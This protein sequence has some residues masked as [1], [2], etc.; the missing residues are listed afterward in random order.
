[1]DMSSRVHW[2]A[3][4]YEA[5]RLAARL[6]PSGLPNLVKEA[7]EVA[8]KV[9]GTRSPSQY[10][11][12]VDRILDVLTSL[13]DI[14]IS[15]NQ[16]QVAELVQFSEL[17][18]ESGLLLAYAPEI[19]EPKPDIFLLRRKVKEVVNSVR[20][21]EKATAGADNAEK[22]KAAEPSP[23]VRSSDASTNTD[24]E[25]REENIEDEDKNTANTD[26]EQPEV[27]CDCSDGGRSS[28]TPTQSKGQG[29][30]PKDT[31]PGSQALSP[32]PPPV[33]TS[34][35]LKS[36]PKLNVMSGSDTLAALIESVG[37]NPN[38]AYS[39][40]R[41][42]HGSAADP[43]LLSLIYRLLKTFPADTHP[44]PGTKIELQY[45]SECG[46]IE[47]SWGGVDWESSLATVRC[48]DVYKACGEPEE[49]LLFYEWEIVRSMEPALEEAP[50]TGGSSGRNAIRSPLLPR[51]N[52]VLQK[53]INRVSAEEASHSACIAERNT[54]PTVNDLPAVPDQSMAPPPPLVMTT[55]SKRTAVNT[56]NANS[57]EEPASGTAKKKRKSAPPR[58]QGGLHALLIPKEHKVVNPSA[59]LTHKGAARKAAPLPRRGPPTEMRGFQ[60]PA[61]APV[62][63]PLFKWQ[64]PSGAPPQ[65]VTP[66][67]LSAQLLRTTPHFPNVES[68]LGNFELPSDTSLMGLFE[69]TNPFALP[70]NTTEGPSATAKRAGEALFRQHLEAPN[71][72]ATND[73]WELAA[74]GFPGVSNGAI[75]QG[76]VSS[77]GP[78][79]FAALFSESK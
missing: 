36:M 49:F 79:M 60:L 75:S 38:R 4:E 42:A 27:A 43:T 67:P 14:L 70:R 68:L 23:R 57:L 18:S 35:R 13:K 37:Q 33:L 55:R 62:L 48:S 19:C 73:I 32:P 25:D 26:K 63:Q 24:R 51:L 2:T 9:V 56:H 30:A 40:G 3:E 52:P 5:F 64:P 12:F 34:P 7:S 17:L 16:I 45:I 20:D 1:M 78:R 15:S 10:Q 47:I 21:K 58:R 44:A 65:E 46:D 11:D 22:Q 50:C 61:K 77:E 71:Q 41:T 28:P 66:T 72:M 29:P 69:D 6:L 74:G 54:S 53:A 39:W 31:S 8:A 59:P 76:G